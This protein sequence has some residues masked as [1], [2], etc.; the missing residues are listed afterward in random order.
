M[1]VLC[2]PEK[3]EEMDCLLYLRDEDLEGLPNNPNM[4][5]TG[6]VVLFVYLKDLYWSIKNNI[7]NTLNIV[8]SLIQQRG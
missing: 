5:R 4:E 7:V 6:T 8:L 3:M 2:I 1:L